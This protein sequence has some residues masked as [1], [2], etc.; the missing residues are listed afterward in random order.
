MFGT[1]PVLF[2][3]SLDGR[4]KKS[5][6]LRPADNRQFHIQYYTEY[7]LEKLIGENLPPWHGMALVVCLLCNRRRGAMIGIRWRRHSLSPFFSFPLSLFPVSD[8]RRG[9]EEREREESGLHFF[10]VFRAVGYDG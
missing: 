2:L 7:F 3:F 10:S 6:F 5:S 8:R 1:V 4:E 9:K